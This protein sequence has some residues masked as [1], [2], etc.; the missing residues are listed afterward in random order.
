[1]NHE[2]LACRNATSSLCHEL[3]IEIGVSHRYCDLKMAQRNAAGV[4]S[5]N[6]I[7]ADDFFRNWSPEKIEQECRASNSIRERHW[8]NELLDLNDWPVLFICGADHVSP[9]Q[10][11]LDENE[12]SAQVAV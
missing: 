2:A 8:M 5:V 11:M 1:M 10:Q 4:R 3:A 12:L 6:D 9:F 7:K